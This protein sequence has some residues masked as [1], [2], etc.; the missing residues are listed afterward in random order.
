MSELEVPN[1]GVLTTRTEKVWLG[2]DGILRAV[3]A[4]GLVTTLDDA[5]ENVLAF[6]RAGGGTRRLCVIDMRAHAAS[7]T[8]DARE[9]YA[10][11]ENA[12]VVLA[13]ALLVRSSIGRMM[14]N[15]FLGINKTVFPLRLFGEPEPAIEWLR[16]LG[17]E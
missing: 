14:G 2:D 12:K 13:V 6:G 7:A 8:R 15:F 11:P 16:G 4:P 9:Y 1:D 17:R 3:V 5:K 10:G